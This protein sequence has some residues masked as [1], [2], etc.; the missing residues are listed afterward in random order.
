MAQEKC[1]EFR[2][3]GYVFEEP[4]ADPAFSA[5]FLHA[6]LM[7]VFENYL[8]GGWALKKKKKQ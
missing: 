1:L 3:F 6:V 7:Q 2:K 5:V 8:L 4:R